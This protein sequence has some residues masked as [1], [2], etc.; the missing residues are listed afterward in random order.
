MSIYP[1]PTADQWVV[2]NLSVDSYTIQLYDL[3]GQQLYHAKSSGPTHTIDASH[4]AVGV[5]LAK[6]QSGS[7]EQTVRLIKY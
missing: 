7:N 2:S 6:I 1:N 5:Y 3:N 4:Y